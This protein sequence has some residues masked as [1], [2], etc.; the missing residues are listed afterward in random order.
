MPRLARLAA[1]LGIGAG[2]LFAAPV[3]A[4]D[5]AC[6]EV[7]DEG[8]IGGT[9]VQ[10]RGG[11][12]SG[13][14]GTGIYGAITRV[15][16]LCVNGLYVHLSVATQI[17]INGRAASVDR[18]AVGQ[19]VWVVAETREGRLYA[20][21]VEALSA[22]VG[23][24][25]AIDAAGR[26]LE[27]GRLAVRVP[28]DAILVGEAGETLEDL[29][30]LRLGQSLDVSGLSE[31]GGELAATRIARV[32]GARAARYHAPPL[33]R[34]VYGASGL[35][36]LSVEGFLRSA[37]AGHVRV[38]DLDFDA[39]ALGSAAALSPGTRVWVSGELGAGGALRA[40]G[41]SARPAPIAPEPRMPEPPPA[42]SRPRPAPPAPA[43]P[44]SGASDLPELFDP[45]ARDPVRVERIG[46]GVRVPPTGQPTGP[47]AR[48]PIPGP[49]LREPTPPPVV[50][51]PETDV[52]PPRSR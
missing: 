22:A 35:G 48:V 18:L 39:S 21:R 26:R 8:G 49:V 50:D 31:P 9:G 12:D 14:G 43:P 23:P 47:P 2:L 34:L 52:P 17:S 30:Q 37:G 11:D 33:Q 16:E 5:P 27:L 24:L 42:P 10:P 25:T 44:P 28:M 19:V 45:E 32:T 40:S 15:S 51:V 1:L 46:P 4:A 6:V 3:H 38:N 29:G 7:G 41:V 36:R 13:I 20:D